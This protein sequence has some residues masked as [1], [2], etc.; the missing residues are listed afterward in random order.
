RYQILRIDDNLEH[1]SL[2]APIAT[3]DDLPKL[4]R[5]FERLAERELV[6][7][8]GK[9]DVGLAP[10]PTPTT[11]VPAKNP[12]RE[13]SAAPGSDRANNQTSE[14]SVAQDK[15]ILQDDASLVPP[16]TSP[17]AYVFEE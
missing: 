12:I 17:R 6:D 8:P 11:A 5:I 4:N 2:A 10:T 3:G 14:A 1:E 16:V 15:P 13:T 7:N 9:T